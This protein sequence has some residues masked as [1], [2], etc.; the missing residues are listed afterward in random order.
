MIFNKTLAIVALSLVL[1]TAGYAEKPAEQ[2]P[3]GNAAKLTNAAGS[4]IAYPFKKVGNTFYYS[5][6]TVKQILKALKPAGLATL[7]AGKLALYV[8]VILAAVYGIGAA[9]QASYPNNYSAQF[10]NYANP[11]LQQAGQA[12]MPMVHQAGAF[13]SAKFAELQHW[14]GSK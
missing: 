4:L 2:T 3:V 5:T 10:Y 13:S 7:E 11:K 1:T 9:T 8:V 6:E 14:I 12:V